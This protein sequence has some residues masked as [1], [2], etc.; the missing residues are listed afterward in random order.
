LHPGSTDRSEGV[1]VA[2]DGPAGSGK[3]TLA[4]LLAGRLGFLYLDSGAL[5]RAVTLKALRE[6]ADPRDG[7]RLKALLEGSRIRLQD[8][9]DGQRTLL[10]GRDVSAEIRGPEVTAA[11]PLV[12]A[13]PGV[14]DGIVRLQRAYVE[15]SGGR[16]V[17]VEGRDIATVVFPEARV[18]FFLDASPEERAR[19]R[20]AQTGGAHADELDAMKRR[21]AHDSGRAVA[22]LRRAEDAETVDTTGLSVE[23]VLSVLESVARKRLGGA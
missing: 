22:P 3:S 9:S 14:R 8:G 7:A 5:Y 6:G 16:G 4:R 2:I 20:A 11:V 18:K 15:E 21:D 23:Q 19:R 13:H 17:V 1:V 12:A 10:D